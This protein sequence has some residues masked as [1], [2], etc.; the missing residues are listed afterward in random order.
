MTVK[1]EVFLFGSGCK[2][3]R[4]DTN[5]KIIA[6]LG[7]GIPSPLEAGR[8]KEPIFR[9]KLPKRDSHTAEFWACY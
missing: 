3:Q 2:P 1:E 8:Y 5:D 6:D 9:K 7:K 4:N